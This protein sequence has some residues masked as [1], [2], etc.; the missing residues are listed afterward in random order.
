MTG[1]YSLRRLWSETAV[2]LE[3]IP[4]GIHLATVVE[5][6]RHLGLGVP[7][8]DGRRYPFHCVAI[9]DGSREVDVGSL[10]CV[11][12]VASTGGSYQAAEVMKF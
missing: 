10:V 2:S 9:T 7:D 3:K 4:L 6:S 11:R 5:F 1:D 8:V 12:L